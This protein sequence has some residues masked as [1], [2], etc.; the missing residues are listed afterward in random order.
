MEAMRVRTRRDWWR[1]M[2]LK[3][4]VGQVSSVLD[5]L[6]VGDQTQLDERLETVADAQHQAVPV[7]QQV[8]GWHPAP[9]ALRKKAVMNLAE[10]SGSSPPEKPPGTKMIW[11]SRAALAKRLMESATP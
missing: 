7:F 2:V 9:P 5:D 10:P 8:H 1:L 4:R 11:L 6:T 3:V